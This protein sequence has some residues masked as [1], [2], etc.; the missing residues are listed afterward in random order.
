MKPTISAYFGP[1]VFHA[2][3]C[4]ETMI[5]CVHDL[6]R[7]NINVMQRCFNFAV[8]ICHNASVQKVVSVHPL[9]R[10]SIHLSVYLKFFF[11][12]KNLGFLEPC[13]SLNY[14]KCLLVH[15][16]VDWPFVTFHFWHQRQQQQQWLVSDDKVVESDIP[17]SSGVSQN[18]VWV[19]VSI[20]Q[21]VSL[22]VHL[23]VLCYLW[24]AT[25]S[26]GEHQIVVTN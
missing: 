1:F 8:L 17:P 6:I 20:N 10:S 3:A 2:F 23:S 21:S 25:K 5:G 19:K 18:K 15:Q 9:V 14:K 12:Y 11:N 13:N 22:S 7:M 24:T 4:N 16:S 26:V